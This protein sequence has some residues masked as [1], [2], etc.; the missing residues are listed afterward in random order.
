MEKGKLVSFEIKNF[1]PFAKEFKFCTSADMSKKEL[2]KN[3][4][5]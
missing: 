2:I 4:L 5:K 1:G 3:M